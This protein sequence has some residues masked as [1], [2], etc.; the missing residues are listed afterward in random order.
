MSLGI[1]AIQ[2][3][4]TKPVN[5]RE[6]GGANR[7][8]FFTN[9]GAIPPLSGAGYAEGITGNGTGELQADYGVGGA[10][11]AAYKGIN[12]GTVGEKFDTNRLGIYGF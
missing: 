6:A 8:N 7:V 9:P 4:F 11:G 2:N 10:S 12:H 3:F 5:E 1:N